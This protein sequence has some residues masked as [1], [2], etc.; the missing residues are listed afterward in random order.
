MQINAFFRIVAVTTALL[1]SMGPT[2]AD[3]NVYSCD[4]ADTAGQF[5][6]PCPA[7]G[8][9]EIALPMP[10]G[11][12]MIFRSVRVPGGSFWHDPLR[13]VRMGNPNAPVYEGAR[14]VSVAGSFPSRDGEAWL[15]WMG[16]YEVTVAQYIAVMGQGDLGR[17]VQALL[18]ASRSRPGG[19][20]LE[21]YAFLAQGVGG[22]RSDNLLSSPV[23]GLS[24]E[25]YSAFIRRYLDWCDA[26]PACSAA[27]PRLDGY[28]ARLRL[29][30]EIEWEYVARGGI[31]PTADPAWDWTQ[32]LPFP[33]EEA[34]RYAHAAP[35]S[36]RKATVVGRYEGVH[37]FYDLFGNVRELTEDRFTAEPGQGKMG[38]YT[39]R[40]GGFRDLESDLHAGARREFVEYRMTEE[41]LDTGFKRIVRARPTDVGIRL[42]LG[43][44]VAPTTSFETQL[45]EAYKAY[46]TGS[47]LESSATKAL[48]PGT[49]QAAEQLQNIRDLVDRVAALPG[50]AIYEKQFKG[51]LT[52]IELLLDQANS[53]STREQALGA[54]RTLAEIAKALRRARL[55]Q[56]VLAKAKP[57]SNDSDRVRKVKQ[58]QAERARG[59]IDEM[60]TFSDGEIERYIRVAT[61]VAGYSSYV[62]DA[63]EQLSGIIKANGTPAAK[64]AF[65]QT[66][67]H[68]EQIMQ[69]DVDLDA[70]RDAIRRGF[71]DEV[72]NFE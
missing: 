34:S 39:L 45:S 62:P 31:D 12:Q 27:L 66:T 46:R 68:V 67:R 6:D 7:P 58:R 1:L 11:L 13:L 41:T 36:E 5:F 42:A 57:S 65:R 64:Y 19:P 61:E 2:S 18:E 59:I 29:P 69:G 47:R 33:R 14:A 26:D 32:S 28:P 43:S 48:A 30:S 25:A 21:D 40:G 44:P 60:G 20:P 3:A 38:D 35:R 70:L 55:A 52:N 22:P 72:L 49:V 4:G 8:P 50:A 51:E 53:K 9:E 17:G 71:P 56:D 15:I 54:T 10:L 23:R 63:F 37:G 16:K 24:H